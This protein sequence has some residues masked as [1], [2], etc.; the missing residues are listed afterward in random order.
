MTGFYVGSH[1]IKV[2]SEDIPILSRFTWHVRANKKT[3]YAYTNIKIGG[4]NHSVSMHRLL[5]G[6]VSSNIDHKN[7]DGLDNRKE[8]LR[9][10]T[11]QQNSFNRV[12]KNKFG[13]RGVYQPTGCS[14]FAFQLRA[15]KK[16]VSKYGFKTAEEAARAYDIASKEIH[17]E[18]GIR[19]FED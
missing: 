7:R 6:M 1:Y 2:D 9:H 10:A 19:N 8:N 16:H 14:T 12:R 3:H 13:Y 15:G 5:T 18:F 11:H 4:K 17:G